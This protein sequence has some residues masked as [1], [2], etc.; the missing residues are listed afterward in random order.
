M[1]IAVQAGAST[2]EYMWQKTAS[3]LD[4]VGLA[5]AVLGVGRLDCISPNSTMKVWSELSCLRRAG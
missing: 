2:R 5:G 3:S 1:V 4:P